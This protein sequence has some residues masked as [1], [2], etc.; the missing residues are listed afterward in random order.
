M[1]KKSVP[2]Y[3]A[4]LRE[5]K[6]ACLCKFRSVWLRKWKAKYIIN[7]VLSAHFSVFFGFIECL[8]LSSVFQA[9]LVKGLGK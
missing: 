9:C 3:R 6:A 5:M 2:V 7:V 4:L 1:V 8:Q